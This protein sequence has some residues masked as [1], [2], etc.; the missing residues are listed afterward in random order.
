MGWLSPVVITAKILLQKL[1]KLQLD[2]DTELTGNLLNEWLA[3]RTNLGDLTK[4]MIPRWTGTLTSRKDHWELHGFADASTL[5]YG[6]VVYLKVNTTEG[7]RITL[8]ASKT[9]VAPV[10]E[11]TVPRLELSAADLLSKLFAHVRKILEVENLPCICWSDSTIVL[12]WIRS[13]PSK[14]KM[15]VANRLWQIHENLPDVPWRH[16]PTKDN[17]ADLASRGVVPADLTNNDLWWSGPK[18]LKDEAETWPTLDNLEPED[19]P[20]PER[21][22]RCNVTVTSETFA[23]TESLAHRFSSWPKLLR[24]T[25]LVKRKVALFRDPNASDSPQLFFQEAYAFWIRHIQTVLFAKEI[26][27]LKENKDIPKGKLR[28]LDPFIDQKGLLRAGGRLNNSGLPASVR[29]PIILGTHYLT[30]LIIRV[31]HLKTLHGGPQLM[32]R[33]LRERYWIFRART[34]V[35]SCVQKCVTCTRYRARPLTQKMGD[36]PADRVTPSRV[37][38]R[39]GVDYAGPF[40]VRALP[41]RGRAARKGFV[42]VFVCLATRAIH[43]EFVSDYSSETFLAAF[44]RFVSRYGLPSLVRSDNGTTFRGAERELRTAFTSLREDKDLASWFVTEGIDW[45]FIPPNAP[46]FGGIWEAG[47][48]STKHHL[49]RV[50]NNQT[51]TFEEMST[52]LAMIG[53]C[54]NSRPIAPLSDLTD[55]FSFLTPGHFLNG[56]APLAVPEPDLTNVNENRLTRWERVKQMR[57]QFWRTWRSD[58]VLQLQQ[59]RKW[60]TS[61]DNLT[62]GDLVLIRSELLPPCKWELGRVI[63]CFPGRENLVRVVKVKT[64]KSTYVRA[65]TK[66]VLLPLRSKNSTE[67]YE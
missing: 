10:K 64:A 44:R 38:D 35:R 21:K 52:L 36:L 18:W 15:F 4:I 49:R 27:S 19:M 60:Q 13:N 32:L 3:F 45:Q 40:L 66:L 12:A 24:F 48:K 58:Y 57:D 41:G 6:A 33:I 2:W 53:A 7:T 31:E 1:W 23:F 59:K 46:H 9:R 67:D 16:V 5:A 37:F 43:L 25:A 14:W 50:I 56:G 65:I 28:A 34:L 54:L 63:E 42:A 20:L 26:A 11:I 29:N 61:R 22:I 8:L 47:V 39:V 62:E 51:L 30:T 55:D 17:P